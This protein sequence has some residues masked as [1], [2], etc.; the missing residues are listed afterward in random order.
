MNESTLETIF[1]CIVRERQGILGY[2]ARGEKLGI[3]VFKGCSEI[4]HQKLFEN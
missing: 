2:Y 1:R 4:S 3:L